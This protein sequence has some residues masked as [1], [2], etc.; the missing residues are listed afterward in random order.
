MAYM[1]MGEG[2]LAQ[3]TQM[4]AIDDGSGG[5]QFA[6]PVMDPETGQETYMLIDPGSVTGAGVGTPGQQFMVVDQQTGSAEL[7]PDPTAGQAESGLASILAE[8][9]AGIPDSFVMKGE[10]AG[11]NSVVM[12]PNGELGMVVGSDELQQHGLADLMQP[13]LKEEP[14]YVVSEQPVPAP[15]LSNGQS[16]RYTTHTPVNNG[17]SVGRT[18]NSGG[19]SSSSSSSSMIRVVGIQDKVRQ[20]PQVSVVKVTD[21]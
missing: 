15:A 12:L 19:S 4:V 5:Q 7:L 13:A 14:L 3:S 20:S 8:S 2:E 11:G 16:S 21:Q 18:V 1:V 10:E 17:I 9:A 6:I